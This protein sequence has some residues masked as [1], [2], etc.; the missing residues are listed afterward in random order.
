M[1]AG[2]PEQILADKK[3]SSVCCV[4]RRSERTSTRSPTKTI[5][6][7]FDPDGKQYKFVDLPLADCASSN[8]DSAA[9]GNIVGLSLFPG[10]SYNEKQVLSLAAGD[11][12]IPV[13]AKVRVVWGEENGGAAKTTVEPHKQIEVGAVVSPFPYSRIARQTYHEGWRTKGIP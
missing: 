7:L 12:R 6:P 4:T 9:D 1:P 13:G 5:S 10:Y 3:T 2:N 8:Y 11:P